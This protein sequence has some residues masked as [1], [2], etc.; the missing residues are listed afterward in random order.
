MKQSLASV[1]SLGK[2]G[3]RVTAGESVAQFD[4]AVPLPTF[5]SRYCQRSLALPDLG[6][7]TPAFVAAVTE[8]V[9]DH[10]IARRAGHWRRHDR[11]AAPSPAAA[12]RTWLRPRA[13]F[14]IPPRH[15]Q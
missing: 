9:R 1:R 3:L 13:G 12:G 15:R 7:D 10:S 11:G 4:P 2:A 5:R 14:R 8:F 6:L